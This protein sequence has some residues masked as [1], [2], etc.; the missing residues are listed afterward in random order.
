MATPTFSTTP[1][2][3]VILPT[4]SDV[5]QQPETKMATKNRQYAISQ[6]CHP[7]INAV[8]PRGASR[9]RRPVDLSMPP[10]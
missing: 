3:I 4:L 5:G 6:D 7:R 9:V 8:E 10:P 1:G 2:S